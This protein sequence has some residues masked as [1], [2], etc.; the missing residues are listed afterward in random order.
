MGINE[1]ETED[2][3]MTVVCAREG[4]EA[5][6]TQPLLREYSYSRD[7][8]FPE[9]ERAEDE[10][11]LDHPG[12]PLSRKYSC[13]LELGAKL[14]VSDVV[15]SQADGEA[16]MFGIRVLAAGEHDLASL[17]GKSSQSPATEKPATK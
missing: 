7:V 4:A 5:W 9:E 3:S 1:F 13:K 11:K 17:L 14:V 8:E 12:L 16:N 10:E 2:H 15:G 6:C